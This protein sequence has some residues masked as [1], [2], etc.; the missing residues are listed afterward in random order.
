MYIIEIV[1]YAGSES[2]NH[3]AATEDSER[4]KTKRL[5]MKLEA[6]TILQLDNKSNRK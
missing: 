4:E 1:G 6:K 5:K 3:M 2:Q